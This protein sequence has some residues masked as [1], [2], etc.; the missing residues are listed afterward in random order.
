MQADGNDPAPWQGRVHGDGQGGANL[1]GGS[2]GSVWLAAGTVS[3]G[4]GTSGRISAS[5]AGNGGAGRIR[6]DYMATDANGTGTTATN[7]SRTAPDCTLGISTPLSAQSQVVFQVSDALKDIHAARLELALGAPAGA[8]YRA[9]AAEPADFGDTLAPGDT[10]TFT[11]QPGGPALG[12]FFRWRAELQ[13][14]PGATQRL[15]GLQWSLDV[16]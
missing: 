10:A 3:L 1:G 12:K 2:G 5:G 4:T 16:H 14:P 6:M 11:T 7:C 9:S 13:P 8:I 15:F